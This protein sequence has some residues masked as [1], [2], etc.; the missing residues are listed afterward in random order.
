[1]KKLFILFAI[2]L[3][4][5]SLVKA[6]DTIAY[7][8]GKK[9]VGHVVSIGK[10][11]TTYTE[12]P[13][14][15]A[16]KILNWRLDYVRYHGG[17]QFNFPEKKKP[18]ASP[19]EWFLSVDGGFTVPS[20]SYRDAIAGTY[21]GIRSTYYFNSRVGW[22]VKAGL[23]LNGTG[24]SYISDNYWG[25]FYAFQE[26]MTGVSFRSGGLP[27]YPFLDL[28]GLVGYC[29]A[30]S[31]VSESGGGYYGNTVK[32]PGNGNGYAFYF[33]MDFTS[34]SDHTCSFTFGVGCL[35]ALFS[36]SNYVTSYSK[37]DPYSNTTANTVSKSTLSTTLLLPEAY[38]AINFRAKKATK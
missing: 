34:S 4:S 26:Y 28:V 33:G 30:N 10:E 12:P 7:R 5:F 8:N 19:S 38:F 24:L 37:Y 17:T 2:I 27:G 6:Q 14:T 11:K 32:T 25:G 23:D 36:Y 1:M 35:G 18:K 29:N 16:K 13:D 20:L 9:V 15:V 31:P 22:V 21:F 3:V